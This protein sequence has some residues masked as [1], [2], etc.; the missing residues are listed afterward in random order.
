MQVPL[1]IIT[2]II[3]NMFFVQVC[4]N[5]YVTVFCLAALL[6]FICIVELVH[7][8]NCKTIDCL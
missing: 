7:Y 2:A 5:C 8:F 6:P 3:P 4:S 1:A